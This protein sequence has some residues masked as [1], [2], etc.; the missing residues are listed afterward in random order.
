MSNTSS[1]AL[2][3]NTSVT[4]RRLDELAGRVHVADA[5]SSI[6]VRTPVTGETLAS[7]PASTPADVSAAVARAREAQRAWEATSVSE[8]AAVLERFG[9]LVTAN[10]ETLQDLVQLE[11]GKARSHAFEEL[12]DVPSTC[13]YYADITADVL[14]DDRRRGAFPLV[15]DAVV[16]ADPL[17]VVGVISPWNYPLTLSMTDAVP[18]LMAGNAVV[19]K[20]DERTPFVALALA[21]LLER[22]GVPPGVFQV[23]TGEGATVGPALIDEVDY[24]AFTGGTETGRTVAERA[25]RNLIGCSLELGGKNPLVVLDDADVHEA[26]RGAAKAAFTNAGQLCLAPERIY[27]DERRYEAFLDALVEETRS[28]TL[29]HAFDYGPDVGSL[30]DE[31]HRDR[32]DE[33]VREAVDDGATVVTGG[34]DR[35][36]VGP[37][38]YEPTILTGVDHADRIACAETFGPVVTV[39]PVSDEAEA[40][41][42]ANDSPYGLNASVWTGDRERGRAVARR[43]NC[44][45]VC[46]NDGFVVGWSAIDAPMGGIGDSGLGRRHGP[47]GV[48][49]FLATR[50][51][52]TSRVGPFAFPSSVPMRWVASV[53]RGVTTVRRRIRRWRR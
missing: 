9:D 1:S 14:A 33:F 42:R 53:A 18:A 40:V 19:C 51:V 30:I 48:S 10:R 22:A 4:P 44:G 37:C 11:T 38:W 2:I 12:L 29:E 16:T 13:S 5:E 39:T 6:A 35:P 43:I 31:A 24:V 3:A 34:R 36:D 32:V 26:A 27:V 52:A 21:D 47:E 49:R 28:L 50:T 25:G 46:V 15:T 8:R 20:P 45:T 23:V 41:E 7:V 17:G